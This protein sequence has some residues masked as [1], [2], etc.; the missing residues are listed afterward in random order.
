MQPAEQADGHFS[1]DVSRRQIL[2]LKIILCLFSYVR[3][4]NRTA[5]GFFLSYLNR[6]ILCS[7]TLFVWHTLW[8]SKKYRFLALGYCKKTLLV[9]HEVWI[10]LYTTELKSFTLIKQQTTNNKPVKMKTISN[11]SITFLNPPPPPL[12]HFM[13]KNIVFWLW[14]MKKSRNIVFCY[15][16]LSLWLFTST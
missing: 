6:Q 3:H 9:H 13:S 14:T 16:V 4:A 8:R 1:G 12:W 10:V 2:K 15:P 5:S 11:K 7:F